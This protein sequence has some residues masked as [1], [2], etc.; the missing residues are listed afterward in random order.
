MDMDNLGSAPDIE[1]FDPS[2][3]D[4]GDSIEAPK[5]EAPVEEPV[6]DKELYLIMN[7]V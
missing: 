4:R 1:N 7:S 3:M 5:V 2:A 6:E